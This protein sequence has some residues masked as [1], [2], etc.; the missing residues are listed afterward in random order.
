MSKVLKAEDVT[1]IA[2]D[3]MSLRPGTMVAISS[4]VTDKKTYCIV[5]R[6]TTESIVFYKTVNKNC[7]IVAEI[8]AEDIIEYDLRIEVL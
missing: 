2:I 1:K 8:T 7:R 5:G 4:N 6:M 3:P